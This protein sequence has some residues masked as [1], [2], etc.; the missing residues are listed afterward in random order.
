ME[1]LFSTSLPQTTA[2]SMIDPY[3]IARGEQQV[4]P[5]LFQA[6]LRASVAN[7][8]ALFGDD[9]QTDD[10]DVFG[11]AQ[12]APSQYSNI[13]QAANVFPDSSQVY[14]QMINKSGLIGKT[15]DA[16]DPETK[17]IITGKIAG[18]TVES[19]K[20]QILING[21]AIPPENLLSIKE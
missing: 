16:T 14:E 8:D 10:A 1:N 21:K 17:Q 20:L 11:T 18:V 6:Y 3:K 4:D 12:D 9:K 13:P 2:S 5:K 19:G 15:V 7:V